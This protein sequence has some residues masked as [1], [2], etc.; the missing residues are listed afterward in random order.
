MKTI[1]NQQRKVIDEVALNLR[2]F[3]GIIIHV[4]R[5]MKNEGRRETNVKIYARRLYLLLS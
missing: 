2:E 3:I 5:K 4:K 1:I